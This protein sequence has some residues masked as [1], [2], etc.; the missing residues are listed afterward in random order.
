MTRKV[1]FK[2]VPVTSVENLVL[3][4]FFFL[5]GISTIQQVPRVLTLRIRESPAT[6]LWN[7]K[8]I[9]FLIRLLCVLQDKFSSLLVATVYI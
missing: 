9:V 1:N 3:T 8:I 7:Q 6:L 2:F 5:F 4:F